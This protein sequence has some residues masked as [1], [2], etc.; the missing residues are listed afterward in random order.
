M[1]TAPGEG[2]QRGTRRRSEDAS[3]APRLILQPARQQDGEIF[4]AR[5]WSARGTRPSI[6]IQQGCPSPSTCRTLYGVTLLSKYAHFVALGHPYT[7]LLV[8]Q[9]FFD[10]IVSLHGLSCRLSVIE[11]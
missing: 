4:C 5:V 8:A 6:Y 9:V 10:Q 3:S 1:A 11:I 7:A 2:A